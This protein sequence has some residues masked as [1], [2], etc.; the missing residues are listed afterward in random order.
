M[1][2]DWL[3]NIQFAYAWVLTLLLIVPVI[4]LEHLRKKDKQDAS[5]MVTTTHFLEQE[6]SFAPAINHIPFALRIFTILCFIVALARPQVVNKEQQLE[7]EGIDI[8]LCFD[9]SGS[10]MAR[11]FTPNRLEAAKEV[12]ADFIENRKGDRIGI[13]IFS[14]QSFTMCP[15]TTDH[16]TVLSQVKA[17]QSGY[18]QDDG[19]AIGSGLAT[20]VDRL[21][22]SSSKSKIIVLLTDGVDF[23]GI[24]PPDIAK[25]MAILYNIKIYSIG[26]GS[27]KEVEELVNTPYGAVNQKKKL[28]FN[29]GL[30]K[31]LAKETGGE[32]FH[33]A[34]KASLR[35]IYNSIDQLEKSKIKS[36][37]Y[38]RYTDVFYPWIITGLIALFLELVLRYTY[39]RKFP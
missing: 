22:N 30:L 38:N 15:I 26:I 29:E 3:N 16:N 11:D 31:E 12:A 23:G 1:I 4:V 6:Q 34:D 10:M 21:R 20:S 36:T 28:D 25:E 14:N 39:F 7:G 33:A 5:M 9:I 35:K 32:Y 19:T 37:Y 27:E 17:V 24:V 18:L 8:V 2:T 13:V